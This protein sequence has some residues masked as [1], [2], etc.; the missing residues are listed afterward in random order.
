MLW[1][2]PLKLAISASGWMRRRPTKRRRSG[3][4]ED[5]LAV[6]LRLVRGQEREW[7]CVARSRMDRSRRGWWRVAT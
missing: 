5:W 1:L 6:V 4:G 3:E 2:D 7:G